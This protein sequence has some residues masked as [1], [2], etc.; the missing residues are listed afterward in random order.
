MLRKQCVKVSIGFI[1]SEELLTP[2]EWIV[3]GDQEAADHTMGA[4]VAVCVTQAASK[5]S[6]AA[7]WR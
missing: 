3:S 6:G 1:S 7:E 4:L 2:Q 5:R